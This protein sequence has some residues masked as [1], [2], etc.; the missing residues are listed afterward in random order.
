IRLDESL[1]RY[2]THGRSRTT[3][4]ERDEEVKVAAYAAIF[5]NNRDFFAEHAESLFRHRHA[6]DRQLREARE[7][8]R[9]LQ[10][11]SGPDASALMDRYDAMKAGMGAA[12]EYL[13]QVYYKLDK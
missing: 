6:L 5:R 13:R 12:L 3:D 8:C 2:R 9:V 1:L 7:R 10:A 11:S 4:F